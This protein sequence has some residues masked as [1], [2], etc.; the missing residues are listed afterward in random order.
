MSYDRHLDQTCAHHVLDERVQSEDGFTLRPLKPIASASSVRVRLN[1][2]HEV[3]PSGLVAPSHLYGSKVGPFTIL[4]NQNTLR[5]NLATNL[6]TVTAPHG[7]GIPLKRLIQVFTEQTK[8]VVF[9]EIKGRLQITGRDMMQVSP[10]PLVDTF[11]FPPTLSRPMLLSPG[12]SLVVDPRE[13]YAIPY[14]YLVFD[15]PFL[16]GDTFGEISYTT[17]QQDCRRCQG[18][19][20]EFDWRYDRSG[21]TGEVRDDALLLQEMLKIFLTD[22]GS[23]PFHPWYGTSL[24]S[25]IGSKI[26]DGK[27]V[28][29]SITADI[30]DA[31][32]KWQSIKRAQEND[33]GQFVSDHE[34][35]NRLL[36]VSTKQDPLDPSAFYVTVLIQ[37]RSGQVVDLT[38]GFKLPSGS[39]TAGLFRQ[40]TH[41]YTLSRP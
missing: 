18:T 27:A 11:G 12:W 6:I 16:T 17:A 15:A 30:S 33:V 34:F 7:F 21:N 31:F 5:I 38:R 24:Q 26:T 14:R 40:S 3:P 39:V 35:P 37:K 29:A 28:Q 19:G 13:K 32:R 25:R 41:G 8:D 20:L 4:P 22:L 36:G 10:S 23:N 1:G 2:F 9:R